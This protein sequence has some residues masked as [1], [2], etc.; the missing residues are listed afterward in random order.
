MQIRGCALVISSFSVFL[1]SLRT[2]IDGAAHAATGAVMEQ[3]TMPQRRGHLEAVMVA[4]WEPRNL[5][6][7]S[8]FFDA[9]L[10]KQKN[11]V[12]WPLNA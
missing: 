2:I 11:G 1:K 6:L 12:P 10:G 9:Q 3:I 8:S 7:P 4:N 5:V